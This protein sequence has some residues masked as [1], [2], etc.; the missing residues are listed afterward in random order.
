M[1][2][3][4]ELD[5][6][7]GGWDFDSAQVSDDK[8]DR[9]Y[10]S[11]L[12]QAATS[13]PSGQ[14]TEPPATSSDPAPSASGEPVPVDVGS[15]A[16]VQQS[17]GNPALGADALVEYTADAGNVVRLPTN[18]SIENIRV[19]GSDLVLEQ[20]DGTL[21]TIKDAASN[22]PTFIIGDVEV[23]RVALRRRL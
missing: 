13:E 18:V 10:G 21:I 15:G 14:P 23:P 4:V 2:T 12:A 7:A 9:L 22:V 5:G 1:T 8:G 6:V 20:A 11:G 16:P 3:S 19:E 17:A